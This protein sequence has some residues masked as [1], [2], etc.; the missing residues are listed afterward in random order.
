MALSVLRRFVVNHCR[1][2]M[3]VAVSFLV[4]VPAARAAAA[5]SAVVHSAWKEGQTV[6]YV[7]TC[8]EHRESQDSRADRPTVLSLQRTI[9][10]T[11]KAE[12]IEADGSGSIQCTLDRID[13]KGDNGGRPIAYDSQGDRAGSGNST[14]D[15]LSNVVGQQ[16]RIRLGQGGPRR[17]LARQGP[18]GGPG[19]GVVDPVHVSRPGHAGL[20]ERGARPA[21]SG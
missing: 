6:S 1:S 12:R 11:L 16:F 14:A 3:V 20:A 10:I 9:H 5:Q 17:D 8:E 4:S 2:S 15:L 18:A 13:L 7:I 19:P 21:D